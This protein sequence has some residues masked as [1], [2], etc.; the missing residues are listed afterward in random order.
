MKTNN[1]NTRFT[2]LLEK[3][4]LPR[5]SAAMLIT[6]ALVALTAAALLLQPAQ[7]ARQ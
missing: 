4:S 1:S 6:T 5:P 2:V 7:A 3:T